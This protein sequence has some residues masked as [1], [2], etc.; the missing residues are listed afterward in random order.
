MTFT[1]SVISNEERLPMDIPG[2]EAEVAS[3]EKQGS[4]ATIM[5]PERLKFVP[6]VNMAVT[7]GAPR[8]GFTWIVPVNEPVKGGMKLAEN[9]P[10]TPLKQGPPDFEVKCPLPMPTDFPSGLSVPF[11]VTV[12]EFIVSNSR[13]WSPETVPVL[14]STCMPPQ[15]EELS[16]VLSLSEEIVIPGLREI[17]IK[18]NRTEA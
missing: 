10:F 2:F 5:E 1:P 9:P 3:E 18:F 12:S 6:W 16:T 14:E 17:H 15:G 7:A 11:K 4:F 8:T 13:N